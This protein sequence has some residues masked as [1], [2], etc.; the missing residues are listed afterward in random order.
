MAIK[1]ENTGGGKK[2]EP[3]VWCGLSCVRRKEK[4]KKKR[5]DK[6]D[7][8]CA[9]CGLSSVRRKGGAKKKETDDETDDEPGVQYFLYASVRCETERKRRNKKVTLVY[10]VS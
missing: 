6:T 7:E 9:W 5:E 1:S 10:G 3:G 2:D 8:A 4:A